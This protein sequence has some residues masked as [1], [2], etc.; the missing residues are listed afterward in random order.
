MNKQYTSSFWS[1]SLNL[2]SQQTELEILLVSVGMVHADVNRPL[3]QFPHVP[4]VRMM[5]AS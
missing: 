3:L 5:L 4:V 2:L 1:L